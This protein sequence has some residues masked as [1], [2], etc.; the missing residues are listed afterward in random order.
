MVTYSAFFFLFQRLHPLLYLQ[1]WIKILKRFY[2]LGMKGTRS[3]CALI[4]WF[5]ALKFSEADG[6]Q[7]MIKTPPRGILNSP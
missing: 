7:S 4:I 2:N 1:N 6:L 5:P 3:K